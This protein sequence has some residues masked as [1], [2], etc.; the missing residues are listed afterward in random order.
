MLR[1]LTLLRRSGRWAFAVG[2]LAALAYPLTAASPKDELLRRV[3]ADVGFVAA[4]QDLRDGWR[5]LHASPFARQLLQTTAD[6]EVAASTDWAKLAELDKTLQQDLGLPWTRLRDDVLG[7]AVVFAYR[8]EGDEGLVLIWA[9]DSAAAAT[10]FERLDVSQ[11]KSGQLLETGARSHAGRAYKHRRRKGEPD[12]FQYQNGQLVAFGSG[13][14]LLKHVIESDNRPGDAAA[15]LSQQLRALGVD[16]ASAVWWVNPRAFDKAIGEKARAASGQAAAVMTALALHWQAL[17]GLAVFLDLNAD[18][19]GGLAVAARSDALPAPTRLFLREAAAP[20]ALAETFPADALVTLTGRLPLPAALQLGPV[21]LP[22]E[23]RAQLHDA[24]RKTLGAVVSPEVLDAL[25]S[26]LGPDWGVCVTRPVEGQLPAVTAAVR[27]ADP[28]GQPPAAGKMFDAVHTLFT[29][30]A[31]GYNTRAA[32]P[33]TARSERQGD[34]EVRY[35]D[36][37]GVARWGIRPAYAWKG[38]YLVVATSPE[39]VRRFTPPGDAPRPPAADQASFLRVALR[40][41][42][43]YLRDSPRRGRRLPRRRNEDRRRRR[44]TTHCRRRRVARPI[45]P[46]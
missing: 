23:A 20:S 2:L 38:G 13:E 9:R 15:P 36:G 5:R 11:K 3:P 22:A 10:M 42:A 33:V 19:R 1:P 18:A 29:F 37:A 21:F 34:V 46:R 44:P 43:A 7:D 28:P 41:W 45:R 14:A 24:A 8:P 12:E 25:P 6:R 32:E 35:F 27:L 26:R 40:G 31:L 30:A 39:V 17:D 4:V 16:S